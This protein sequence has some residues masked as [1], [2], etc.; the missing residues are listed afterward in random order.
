M[1]LHGLL[2]GYLLFLPDLGDR[3]E[4]WRWSTFEELGLYI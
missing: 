1:G 2:Q 4:L 3:E